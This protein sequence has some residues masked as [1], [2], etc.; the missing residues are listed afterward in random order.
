MPDAAARPIVSRRIVMRVLAL[1]A[2][3]ALTVT[4]LTVA[5]PRSAGAA[6]YPGLAEIQAAK[7]AVADAQ[8]GVAELDAAIVELEAAA[9]AADAAA[10]LA[11]DEYAQAK[12]RSDL[13]ER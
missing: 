1:A 8:A 2:A 11:A 7:A 10:R 5:S 13:A 6:D 9:H 12:A 4:S 3:L